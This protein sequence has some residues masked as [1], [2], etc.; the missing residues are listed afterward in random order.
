VENN[1]IYEKNNP[2]RVTSKSEHNIV[3]S[4][5]LV[6]LASENLSA[7]ALISQGFRA[8]TLSNQLIGGTGCAL[9]KI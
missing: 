9:V 5:G 1:L 2:D 6:Y 3:G 4:I 8:P 7:R